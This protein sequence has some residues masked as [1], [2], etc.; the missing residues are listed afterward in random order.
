MHSVMEHQAGRL[1]DDA[2]IVLV[3]WRTGR[4]NRLLL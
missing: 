1:Q 4:E 2:S 3:E